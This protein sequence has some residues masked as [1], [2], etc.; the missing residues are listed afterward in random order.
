MTS[1]ID[2]TMFRGDTKIIECT[3]FDSNANPYNLASCELW[4]TAKRS[5]TEADGAAVM[6][7]G[8]TPLTGITITNPANGQF[9]IEITPANTYS[10]NSGATLLCD[11]QLK[12]TNNR[13]YTVARGTITV[14]E[15]VTRTYT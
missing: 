2:F 9:V 12:D 1:S 3:L 14:V 8:T 4:F 15:D 5:I 7:L 11:I 6:S 10:M 13:V